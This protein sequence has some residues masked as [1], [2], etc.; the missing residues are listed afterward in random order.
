MK[1]DNKN[2]DF[3]DLDDITSFWSKNFSVSSTEG[4]VPV[5][6]AALLEAGL[7]FLCLTTRG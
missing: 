4:T 5:F 7:A 3:N 1:L 6:G 2:K